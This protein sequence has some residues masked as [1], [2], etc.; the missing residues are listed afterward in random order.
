MPVRW[1]S[2]VFGL[3]KSAAA[4]FMFLVKAI[5]R[6]TGVEAAGAQGAAGDA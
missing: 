4:T 2:T 3:M 5:W 6:A 1:T